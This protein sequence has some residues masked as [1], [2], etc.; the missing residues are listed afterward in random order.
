ML[1][2]G[3]IFFNAQLYVSYHTHTVHGLQDCHGGIEGYMELMQWIIISL[4]EHV[5][6]VVLCFLLVVAT[7][8]GV[9]PNSA[10]LLRKHFS[11]FW[12]LFFFLVWP[13]N[14]L[15][16]FAVTAFIS[17]VSRCRARHLVFSTKK[18]VQNQRYITCHLAAAFIQSYG[19]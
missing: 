18:K 5:E 4:V 16:W 8:R 19:F 1:T 12:V 17:I 15:F 11:V 3:M 10:V 7:H 9:S 14:V 6:K 2:A 13:A